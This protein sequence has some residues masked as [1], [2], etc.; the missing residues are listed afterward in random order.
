M[1]QQI[2]FIIDENTKTAIAVLF[3]NIINADG[4]VYESEL[5]CLKEIRHK[6][7]LTTTH[8]KDVK[9]MSL[10]TAINKIITTSKKKGDKLYG[11]ICDDMVKVASVNGS[12]SSEEAMIC[13][14]FRYAY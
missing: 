1:E 12:V 14:A 2:G 11:M 7:S 6:Y 10:A 9:T 8:F 3:T 4:I 5:S 13:L